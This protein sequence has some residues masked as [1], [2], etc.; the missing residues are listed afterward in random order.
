V[1][2]GRLWGLRRRQ[3]RGGGRCR[4]RSACRAA[5]VHRTGQWGPRHC[6]PDVADRGPGAARG[7]LRRLGHCVGNHGALRSRLRDLQRRTT[8]WTRRGLLTSRP[9]WGTQSCSSVEPRTRAPWRPRR[10]SMSWGLDPARAASPAGGV[11]ARRC[12]RHDRRRA[13]G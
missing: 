10:C 12:A 9:S 4:R 5:H 7:W 2:A 11:Q 3:A 1:S 13:R 8:P 6:W